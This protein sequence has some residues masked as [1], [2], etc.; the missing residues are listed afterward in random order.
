MSPFLFAIGM[1]Y[2]SRRL[3]PLQNNPVDKESKKK[4]LKGYDHST[5]ITRFY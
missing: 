5:K 4:Y 3:V 1:E 2:L